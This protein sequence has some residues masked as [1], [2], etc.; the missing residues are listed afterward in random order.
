MLTRRRFLLGAGA[1]AGGMAGLGGYAFA[2]E[3]MLRLTVAE[4]EMT[5]RG[6]PPGFHLKI[7]FLSDIHAI[8]PWMSA[9]RIAGIAALTNTFTP[10][11]VL[12]GGDYEAG[13][14]RFRRLG[15]LVPMAECADALA[16]LRAP[17]G[18]HGVLG[19]HDVWTNNG[20]DVRAAFR[21]RAISLYENKAV[22]LEKDGRPFWLLGLGDQMGL[23]SGTTGFQPQDDLPGTLAQ[24]TDDA[25]AILLAHEPDIFESVPERI[26]LTLSGHTHGGQV[27]LPFLGPPF[28]SFRSHRNKY[29]QGRY[30]E[31]G[32]ELIVTAGLGMSIA[33]MRF[34]VP[35]EIM[36][37][38]LGS[39]GA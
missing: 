9:E 7:A 27:S 28:L 29:V 22:R 21:S 25:P 4:H 19:N 1:A 13:L 32:R 23:W 20:D 26:S 38:H 15:R 2:V 35:P 12:L 18:I 5:P 8:E 39:S 30:S 34:G 31:S 3:P 36:I 37:L 6:W 11:I 10:D 17:L 14:R 16:V 33:P 24:V